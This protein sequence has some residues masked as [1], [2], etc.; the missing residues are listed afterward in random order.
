MAEKT[1]ISFN[2]NKELKRQVNILASSKETT[3]TKLYNE[4]IIAGAKKE[5]ID[6]D[7]ILAD[8]KS[9]V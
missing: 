3:A 7:K 4:W 1:K 9:V 2:I 5:G 8:R 6:I